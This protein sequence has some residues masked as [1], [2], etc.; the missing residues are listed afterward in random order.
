[1]E[2]FSINL[3]EA[4]SKYVNLFPSKEAHNEISEAEIF[5]RTSRAQNEN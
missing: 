3:E 1:M 2:E 4:L 5:T